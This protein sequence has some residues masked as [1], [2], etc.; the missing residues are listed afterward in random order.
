MQEAKRQLA[1]A[2]TAEAPMDVLNELSE[3][4][5][6]WEAARI[7][8][9]D[10]PKITAAMQQ[11][12]IGKSSITSLWNATLTSQLRSDDIKGVEV[13]LDGSVKNIIA[14][15]SFKVALAQQKALTQFEAKYGSGRGRNFVSVLKR[16]INDNVTE[17]VN[18]LLSPI[19]EKTNG[20]F[21]ENLDSG[22]GGDKKVKPYFHKS[23][24]ATAD[25]TVPASFLVLGDVYKI[26]MSIIEKEINARVP[27]AGAVYAGR[28]VTKEMQDAAQADANS[29]ISAMLD[30]KYYNP[31][32]NVMYGVWGGGT[33]SNF[34]WKFSNTRKPTGSRGQI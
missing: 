18:Q 7:A 19:Y 33:K 15:N 3:N 20:T 26:P 8:F 29:K 14:G 34:N 22:K 6:V 13:G 1:A 4:V 25:K 23:I 31:Q 30:S 12:I 21:N 16:G 24:Y 27:Q 9:L 11:D 5:A 2:R 32:Q 17:E 28:V 10:D